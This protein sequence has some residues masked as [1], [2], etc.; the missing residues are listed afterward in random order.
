MP[1]GA[2]WQH[3]IYLKKCFFC[4][5]FGFLSLAQILSN[6]TNSFLLSLLMCEKE[7]S[8]CSFKKTEQRSAMCHCLSGAGCVF[9]PKFISPLK[10]CEMHLAAVSHPKPKVMI[11]VPI[12]SKPP[13]FLFLHV[14]GPFNPFPALLASRQEPFTGAD[15]QHVCSGCS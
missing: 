10:L 11:F 6:L 7:F 5:K 9:P 2:V 14:K 15:T 3:R 4:K 8:R 12:T 1:E 13:L